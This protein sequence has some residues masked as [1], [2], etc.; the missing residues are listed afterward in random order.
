MRKT[1]LIAWQRI[2]QVIGKWSYWLGALT[3]LL[4]VVLAGAA[5]GLTAWGTKGQKSEAPPAPDVVKVDLTPFA[6]AVGYVDQAGLLKTVPADVPEGKFVPYATEAQA[7][8]AVAAGDIVGYYVIPADYIQGGHTAYY[9]PHLTLFSGTDL[10]FR[11]MLKA[12]LVIAG[13]EAA[14]MRAIEAPTVLYRPADD[15]PRQV[16][17]TYTVWQFGLGLAIVALFMWV[18]NS[19][20]P[21]WLSFM[22]AERERGMLEILLTSA[23]PNQFLIGK[24]LAAAFLM[25][26]ES[27]LPVLSLAVVNEGWRMVGPALADLSP[28]ASLLLKE[29][30]P[31][32]F[33]RLWLALAALFLG[34]LVYSAV[35]TICG[36]LIQTP[37]AVGAVNA[38]LSGTLGLAGFL[39]LIS[40]LLDPSG[41]L[42]LILSFFPLT[43]PV[44][45]PVRLLLEQV[46]LWQ[47]WLALALMALAILLCLRL[48][49]YLFQLKR[50]WWG[51][52]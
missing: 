44:F 40:V 46:P 49:V 26:F 36:V 14:V 9:A 41:P 39:L 13:S 45:L 4:S 30:P 35:Y 19:I 42:A 33:D 7:Q 25:L 50:W 43:A 18:L 23:S 3:P 16:R 28:S 31:L 24:L 29:L 12:N 11:E 47:I 8:A 32:P 38:G 37:E 5:L 21:Y 1:L 22:V 15:A 51:N 20:G 27:L 48:A 2:W 17:G 34:L 6:E 52:T 10:A